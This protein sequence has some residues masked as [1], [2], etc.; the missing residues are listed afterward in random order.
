MHDTAA[1]PY[2]WTFLLTATDGSEEL[3][4][5]E[6]LDRHFQ[7]GLR[8]ATWEASVVARQVARITHARV[9]ASYNGVMLA[10]GDPFGW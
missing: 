3:H 7:L 5:L 6:S 8:G 9:E 4:T 2:G 1:R 10:V